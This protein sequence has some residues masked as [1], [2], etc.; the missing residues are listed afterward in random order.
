MRTI[1]GGDT[2]EDWSYI[3]RKQRGRDYFPNY[4]GSDYF[5]GGGESHVLG[6]TTI[7]RYDYNT[8]EVTQPVKGCG[9][10]RAIVDLGDE[11]ILITGSQS[12][13]LSQ[14]N[15]ILISYDKGKN[16]DV[17]LIE[18]TSGD[19]SSG[20]GYRQANSLQTLATENEPCAL[21]VNGA[22][23]KKVYKDGNNFFRVAYLL[24][25][26]IDNS[27]IIINVASGYKKEYPY[28]NIKGIDHDNLVYEIPI[29]EGFGKSLHDSLGNIVNVDGNVEW[30]EVGTRVVR[31]GEP[32]GVGKMDSS[33]VSSAIRIDGQV[34]FGKIP[35]LNFDKNFTITFWLNEK[36]VA[37]EYSE[38]DMLDPQFDEV[39]YVVLK[40]GNFAI[41]RYNA[42]IGLTARDIYYPHTMRYIES[43]L[44]YSSDY[45]FYAIVIEDGSIR[46]H[47]NGSNAFTS[48][49]TN[50]LGFNDK[51]LSEED[52]IVGQ[53]TNVV[54]YI[55]DIKVYN[56]ALTTEEILNIYK[57]FNFA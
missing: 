52:F 42:S 35:L 55:S 39:R 12:T 14:E 45:R 30:E 6:G 9:G 3:L 21:L 23:T 1:D 5:I 11:N 56:K 51:K 20:A 24:F 37:S 15:Q 10:M 31:Y 2:W 27:N 57:G 46:V 40:A 41:V 48:G 4:F 28:K 54:G 50:Y 53:P 33:K 49:S 44:R 25:E 36:A 26:N 7:A 34:N 29:N 18:D 47:V 32:S 22:K 8:Q 13:P 17:L 38:E 19:T 16:W 43:G